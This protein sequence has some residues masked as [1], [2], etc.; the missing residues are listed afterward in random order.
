MAGVMKFKIDGREYESYQLSNN[1]LVD[2]LNDDK[3]TDEEKQYL[4]SKVLDRF[5]Y[6]CCC[7]IGETNDDVFARNFSD[8][9][10]NT[11]HH[12]KKAAEN[13]ARDHRY[14]QNEMFIVCMAYIKE[15]AKSFKNGNFDARN[16]YACE[17]SKL[18]VDYLNEIKQPI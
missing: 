13:M 15:L 18:I 8:Y 6:E 2:L 14:L 17:T 1:Q 9:V 3:L 4:L 11:L 10:N 5:E 12:E 7:R 16:K